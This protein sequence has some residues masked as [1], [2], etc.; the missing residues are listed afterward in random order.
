MLRLDPLCALVGDFGGTTTL[1]MPFRNNVAQANKARE[2][3]ITNHSHEPNPA[4]AMEKMI[5]ELSEK[6]RPK[7]CSLRRNP[8]TPGGAQPLV[9][10]REYNPLA[11]AGTARWYEIRIGATGGAD[12]E[13][14]Q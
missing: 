10:R 8:P 7:S 11:A 3:I 5:G 12:S 14:A 1:R 2:T 4:C 9:G 6:G 13:A